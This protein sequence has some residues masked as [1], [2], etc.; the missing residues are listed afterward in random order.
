MMGAFTLV[1]LLVAIAI[2]GILMGLLLPAIQA[3]RESA[4]R[5]QCANN[6][7]QIGL[8]LWQHHDATG[9]FPAG[10]F[11][12]RIGVCTGGEL[13]GEDNPSQDHVNWAIL[14][15][16][17]LD[18]RPLFEQ[19]DFST[20]NE[21]PE[22]KAVRESQVAVY[23]CPSDQETSTLTVPGFGPAAAWDLNVPYMPGSYR[24]VSGRSDGRQ[25]LDDPFVY[26]YPEAWRG[27]MHLVGILGFDRERIANIEDGTSHT[28]MVGESAS[29]TKS[30]HRTLWAYSYAFYSLSATIPQTRTLWGD[31]ERCR[32][33][34]GIGYGTPC[35]RGWGSYHADGNH[36]VLCD[37][38]VRFLSQ[39]VDVAVF[40]AAGSIAGGESEWLASG[41]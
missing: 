13:T 7:R 37:G 31:Y 1:E 11:A 16:P 2:I 18:E 6:L 41:D 34:G 4:R 30:E 32:A 5:A 15:L 33:A 38:S 21:A 29:R 19:Y 10:N 20:Y 8:A 23:Q 12:S 40:A 25:F 36:F 17:Y 27:V 35:T 14:I 9:H 39:E 22:N 24:A 28:L 26:Q 3:A